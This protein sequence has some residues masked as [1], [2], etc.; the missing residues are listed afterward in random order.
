MG[1]NQEEGSTFLGTGRQRAHLLR[2][3][4]WPLKEKVNQGRRNA[5]LFYVAWNKYAGN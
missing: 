4:W 5:L 1:H 2:G 3:G